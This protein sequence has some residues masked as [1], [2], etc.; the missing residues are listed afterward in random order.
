M[1]VLI[2]RSLDIA[3]EKLQYMR[4]GRIEARPLEKV[5]DYCDYRSICRFDTFLPGCRVRRK[6]RASQADFFGAEGGDGA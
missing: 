5:C 4:A 3:R 6:R 2:E 1:N